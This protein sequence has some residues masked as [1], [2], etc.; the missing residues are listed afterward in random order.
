MT[1]RP[2]VHVVDDD[3]SMRASLARLLGDA[4]YCV[5]CYATG[6]AFLDAAGPATTGCILLDLRLPGASG[7]VLQDL[8]IARQCTAPVIFLTA[9]GDVPSSVHAM[10]HGAWDFLQKPV[11]ADTLFAAIESALARAAAARRERDELEE[12]RARAGTLSERERDVWLRVAR[13]QLNK[14]IAYDLGIVE[15]TVKLHRASA[16]QKLRAA[17]TADLVRIAHRLGLPGDQH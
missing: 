14:Q 8:L 13:G 10:K 6:E 16:T 5:A 7:L 11:R 2:T 3:D 9:H 12:L 1:A 4:G 15:R 17:S